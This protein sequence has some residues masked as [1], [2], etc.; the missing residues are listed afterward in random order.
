SNQQARAH[1]TDNHTVAANEDDA[2]CSAYPVS[3]PQILF[4]T[5]MPRW[6]RA[7]DIAGSA[8]ALAILSPL[9][10]IVAT[11][12]AVV[13]P[14]PIFLKQKR[15]GYQGKPYYIRKFRTMKVGTD[16][17]LHQEHYKTMLND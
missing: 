7:M 9:L 8:I 2:L 3:P 5:G 16:N 12:I 6:K 4:D 17:T 15:V 1:T 11:I 14:G 10:L 13:S